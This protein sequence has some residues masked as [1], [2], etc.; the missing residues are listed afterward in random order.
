M[1]MG[2]LEK[3][4]PEARKGF[5]NATYI[6]SWPFIIREFQEMGYQTLYS[7]DAP[8][9]NTFNYRLKGFKKKPAVKY[10]RPWWLE[11]EQMFTISNRNSYPQKCQHLFMFNYIKQFFTEYRTEKKFLFYSSN[12]AHNNPKTAV[13]MDED[14]TSM[15]KFLREGGHLE[16]TIVLLFADHGD[17]TA[18]FRVTMQGKLEERLPF[19][20]FTFPS[21]F[22]KRFRK[23]FSKFR[24]NSKVL[25]THYD[26]YTTLK[27][28]QNFPRGVYKH[29]HGQSLFTDIVRLNR[30]CQQA[31]IDSHW[32]PCLSYKKLNVTNKLVQNMTQAIVKTINNMLGDSLMTKSL[33]AEVKLGRI[34]SANQRS[35]NKDVEDFVETAENKDCDECSI[36]KNKTLKFKKQI[37]EI[38]FTALPSQGKFEANVEYN[39]ENAEVTVGEISRIN[40]Y[41]KQPHC[42]QKDFPYMR[43]YC[44]CKD[45]VIKK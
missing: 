27:H 41:G 43:K 20:S 34:I 42:I 6:D 1:L 32:C 9:M 25:T 16:N 30:T 19:L 24:K 13:I 14:V 23:E 4:L 29:H 18:D 35:T 7:E 44:Y 12:I 15:Y 45:L 21:W 22:Q 33:C 39:V 38:I 37:F 28:L 40:R 26:T 5:P 3:E 36:V 8:A 31:G 2:R 11:A 10:L 17:R